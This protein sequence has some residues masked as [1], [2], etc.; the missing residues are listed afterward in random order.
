M[1]L[2]VSTIVSWNLIYQYGLVLGIAAWAGIMLILCTTAALL[3]RSSAIGKITWKNRIAGYLIPW[4]H[5]LRWG[6]LVPIVITSWILWILIAIAVHLLTRDMPLHAN[7]P[8]IPPINLIG[9]LTFS[10]WFIF[11]WAILYLVG[12][13]KSNFGFSSNSGQTMIMLVA[14]L[15]AILIAS[16]T[17]RYIGNSTLSLLLTGIPL[18]I[19][20]VIAT[21]YLVAVLLLF[22]K[23]GHH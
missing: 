5:A 14:L 4:G 16:A 1:L 17:M 13:A 23:G 10:C 15:T 18:A 11:T 3:V 6:A 8:S 7:R 12:N 22:R 2:I 21:I 9:V 19:V 20:L